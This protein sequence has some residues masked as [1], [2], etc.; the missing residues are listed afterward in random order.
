M[1]LIN[2]HHL[3][4]PHIDLPLKQKQKILKRKEEVKKS[5]EAYMKKIKERL[6]EENQ[7]VQMT[8]KEFIEYF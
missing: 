2:N 3:C 6:L 1:S 4:L 5:Y 8:L 7:E